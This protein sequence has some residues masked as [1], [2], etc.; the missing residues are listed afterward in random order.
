MI[1]ES[2]NGLKAEEIASE[3]EVDV[4]TTYRDIKALECEI[5]VPFWKEGNRYRIMEG[6]FLPPVQLSL[7]EALSIFLA[8]RLMLH[9][10]HRYDPNIDTTF[11][12]LNSIVPS[13]LKEQVRNTLEWMQ[14]LPKD[15]HYLQTM[16]TLAEAWVKQHMVTVGYKALGDSK[17]EKR[18]MDP[19]FIEPAA[20]GHS[21]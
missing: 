2:R 4:R 11:Q 10:A 12:K 1:H 13:P 5:G 14:K 3:C 7:P 19:Y 6:Y 21:S 8:A 9:Y 17:P 15:E 16:A 20:A 18:S